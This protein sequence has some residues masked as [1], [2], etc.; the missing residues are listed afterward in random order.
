M[1]ELVK[2]DA[3]HLEVLSKHKHYYDLFIKSGELVGFTHDVQQE[4]LQVYRL[5]DPVYTYNNR[6]GACIGTFLV[7]VYKTFNEQ[8]HS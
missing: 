7:N 5:V 2:L 4:L 6:C 8:L 3:K 1:S